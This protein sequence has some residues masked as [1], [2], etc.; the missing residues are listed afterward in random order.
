MYSLIWCFIAQLRWV[1]TEHSVA[2]LDHLAT[3][4]RCLH[5]WSSARPPSQQKQ[6]TFRSK[7]RHMGIKLITGP[8]GRRAT[9]RDGAT[10]G[11][12]CRQHNA[13]A[14]PAGYV[15]RMARDDANGLVWSGTN[16]FDSAGFVRYSQWRRQYSRLWGLVCIPV[17]GQA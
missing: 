1:A 3:A 17:N 9:C 12:S 11:S 13:F 2:H 5:R 7:V 16:G 8:F 4:E 6:S 10:N 15:G 14:S